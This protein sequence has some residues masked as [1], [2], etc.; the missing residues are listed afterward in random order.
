MTH[1][2]YDGV[3]TLIYDPAAGNRAATRAALYTLG[4]R[5]I[6]AA[7]TLDG[8][9]DSVRKRPPDLAVVDVQG[10]GSEVC[11]AIQE[12]RQGLSGHNPFVMIIV[13]ASEKNGALIDRVVN[14]GADDLV[15]RPFSTKMLGT[16][17]E[18]LI[19]RRK[20][21]LVT[22]EYVGPDRRGDAARLSP[23]GAF[24]P[25]NS[26]KLKALG[27]LPPEAITKL[28]EDELSVARAGLHAEKLRRD[29][30]QVCIVWRMLQDRG[31]AYLAA[32]LANL[33]ALSRSMQ[34]R[35]S[36]SPDNSASE[37]CDALHG[38]AERLK[39][40]L[41]RDV[42]IQLFGHA[43]LTLH[44]LLHREKSTIDQISEIDATVALI[45]AR[46]QAATKGHKPD[47]DKNARQDSYGAFL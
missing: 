5:N 45:R 42:S 7:L 20:T 41:N 36:E 19:N 25:P 24:V 16:R 18:A 1:L 3:E 46:H 34:P 47:R 37:L 44:Q 10:N 43:A 27:R 40:E 29:S 13:T 4:F 15:L 22:S 39:Q 21:F 14:S 32:D 38:A 33:I 2:S 12:V 30:F 6:A 9:V 26:L 23:G 35:A 17:I 11:A 8:F 28:L 31:G